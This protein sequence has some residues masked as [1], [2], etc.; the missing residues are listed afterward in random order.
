MQRKDAKPLLVTL[1]IMASVS[2]T[3]MLMSLSDNVICQVISTLGVRILYKP[4]YVLGLSVTIC[5]FSYIFLGVLGISPTYTLDFTIWE[6][7]YK[8]CKDDEES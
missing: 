4:F 5:M 2:F 1:M 8:Y 3:L 6:L 7:E